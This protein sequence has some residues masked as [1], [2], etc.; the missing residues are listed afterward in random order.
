MGS[1]EGTG[2]NTTHVDEADFIQGYLAWAKQNF[3]YSGLGVEVIAGRQ[4]LNLGSRRLVARNAFRNTINSFDGLKVRVL[5]YDNWQFNAFITMPV[6]RYPNVAE[7]LLNDEHRFDEPESNTWFS[8][9]FLEVYDFI[10]GVSGEVYLYHLDEGDRDDR[11]QTRNRR[12]FTPGV[13]VYMKPS[14]GQFDFQLETIGQ[15]GTV[16]A[17]TAPTDSENLT[18][19]AWAQHADAGYTFS[20]PWS[21]RVA[22]EYDYVSGDEDPNDK[23]DQRFDTLFG[24][25]RWEYGPTGIYGAFARSNINTPGY[26]L[27]VAP[28]SDVQASIGHRFFWLAEGKDSWTTSGL[29]DKTGNTDSFVGHQLELMARW[30]VNSSLN[31]E[32]GWAHLFKGEFARNAPNAPQGDDIDYFYVLSQ[33]RF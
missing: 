21:P 7:Q 16:R 2:L 11:S 19:E 24:A 4:T 31:L 29:R 20:L 28:R 33:L 32:S 10:P 27:S 14:K 17:T 30:D 1:D 6:G 13:R 18:H 5:D 26:R 8:G 12:Y 23:S 22:L 3:L 25:R 15:L 9:G